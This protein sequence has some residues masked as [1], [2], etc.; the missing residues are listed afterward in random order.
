[1]FPYIDEMSSLHP[2]HLTYTQEEQW[3][4]KHLGIRRPAQGHHDVGM[5]LNHNFLVPSLLPYLYTILTNMPLTVNTTSF[6]VLPQV[7]II[8]K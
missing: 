8:Y 4:A 6:I 1:M 3:A 2:S 5:A 7:I